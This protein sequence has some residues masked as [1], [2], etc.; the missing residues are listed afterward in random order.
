MV[1]TRRG[2]LVI[3]QYRHQWSLDQPQVHTS[4]HV[5]QLGDLYHI[6]VNC[7]EPTLIMYNTKDEFS[8]LFP[9]LRF[10]FAI[11]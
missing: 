8:V 5:V 3:D 10:T 9:D 4:Y 7:R 11:I 1:S 6:R 2:T